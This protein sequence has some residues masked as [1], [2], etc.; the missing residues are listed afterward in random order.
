MPDRNT[1]AGA[2]ILR[3][4]GK[5]AMANS[6][7]HDARNGAQLETAFLAIPKKGEPEDP[8]SNFVDI[9]TDAM[10]HLKN[11]G[12]DVSPIL[13]GIDDLADLP[14]IPD[15]I[16]EDQILMAGHMLEDIRLHCIAAE[17]DFDAVV[18]IATGH[19]PSPASAF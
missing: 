6:M 5:I 4:Y 18:G 12:S 1:K 7:R 16:F 19:V 11:I 14:T 15:R 9:L 3:N 8:R 2:R 17:I 13:S 10:L